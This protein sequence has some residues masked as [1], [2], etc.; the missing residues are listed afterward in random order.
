MNHDYCKKGGIDDIQGLDLRRGTGKHGDCL[1]YAVHDV[2][3]NIKGYQQIYA[4]NVTK[5]TNKLFFIAK[6]GDKTGS[7]AVIG[8]AEKIQHGFILAE[9]L[10]TSLKIYHADGNGKTTLNNAEKTP[11]IVGLDVGNLETVID[12]VIAHYKTEPKN[13]QIHADNDCKEHGNIGIYKSLVCAK[14]HGIK[15]IYV[16]VSHNNKAVDFAD[17]LE[18]FT[19]AVHD[20]P[21]DHVRQL[22]E[23]AP[24]LQLNKLGRRLASLLTDKTPVDFSYE[25]AKNELIELLTNRGMTSDKLKPILQTLENA[26]KKRKEAIKQRHTLTTKHGIIRHSLH[27]IPDN[28]LNEKIAYTIADSNGGI[29]LDN[30]SLGQ[31]KTKML[32][33]LRDY[34]KM[35][36]IAYVCHRVSLTKDASTRLSIVNYQDVAQGETPLH[37]GL[38]VNSATKHRLANYQILFIDEFRQVLEHIYKGTVENRKECLDTLFYAIQNADL[39]VCLDADLNDDCVQFLKK[40]ASGKTI[41]LIET[42]TPPNPKTI[43]LLSGHSSTYELIRKE[44]ENGGSPFVGCT[45]KTEAKKLQTWLS[46]QCSNKSVLIIHSEN[47]GDSEQAEFLANPNGAKYDCVIHSPTIGSGFSITNQHYTKNFLLNSG[48]LPSN[49]CLQMTARNRCANDIYVSFSTQKIY[50]RVTDLELLEQ[51][52]KAN[53]EKLSDYFNDKPTRGG[54]P[55]LFT[56]LAQLYIQT[57]RAVNADLND[58]ANNFVMLA[59]LKGYAIDRETLEE[60]GADLKGLSKRVKTESAAAIFEAEIIDADFAG[61]LD[62]NQN[63]KQTETNQLNR[64]ETTVMCGSDDITQDDVKHFLDGDMRKLTNYETVNNTAHDC[65]MFDAENAKTENKPYSKLAINE[66]FNDVMRPLFNETINQSKALK[67]CE[68]LRDNAAILAGNGFTDYRK[69]VFKRPITTLGNFLKLFGYQLVEEERERTG[70]DSRNY[71][72]KPIEH[73]ERYAN[74]RKARKCD[75][76]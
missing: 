37:I 74:N 56:D 6:E 69:K 20:K 28:Q 66:L 25:Q 57:Q 18:F 11:V 76:N 50:D 7:F 39:V 17:T 35:F 16:P 64:Y 34:L 58:F 75:T 45:S 53:N 36:S 51:G 24:K 60:T 48:N 42:D 54:V 23:Y 12:A 27:G 62:K 49:E 46:E 3:G 15:K 40:Y 1:M 63:R 65:A 13:V 21:L 61:K 8:D 19:L 14:K 72:I 68:R 70:S 2:Q 44:L 32:E 38:C 4:E 43:H 22:I 29:W 73:I 5:D 47:K 30:R 31:G 52:I 67:A 71:V 33:I 9:G 59:E 55:E 10:K 26:I 41:N